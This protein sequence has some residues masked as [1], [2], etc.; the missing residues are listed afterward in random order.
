MSILGVNNSKPWTGAIAVTAIAGIL[1]FLTAARDIIVGDSPELITAAATLGVAHPPGYPLFT[2]L[3]HLFALIPFSSI[4]FRVNLFS[5]ICDAAAVGVVYW[6]GWR[7]TKSQ[8]DAAVAF[9]I[10]LLPYLYIPWA[11][12]HHP[13]Q[14]WG[15]ISSFHDFVGLITRR[16]Y[17]STKLIST[18]G[19]TG[20]PPWPRLAALGGSFGP[21]A[22][23]L[24]VLGAIHAFQRARWYFWFSLLA[25]IFAG[26]F[27][28]WISDLNLAA[29]PS[30]LFVLQRFFLLSQ[31]TLTPLIAFGVPG[32]AELV[33][34]SLSSPPPF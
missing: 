27:F 13:V 33:A 34:R 18:P 32:L 30:S 17:G 3:G 10:G 9:L 16:S 7:L 8:L 14:N 22:G 31:V 20:G 6:I 15:N 12:W 2:M 4:P 11:A 29:A 21:V 24:I 26:P 1:Y 23:L 5:V 28:I 19:Y 25:F